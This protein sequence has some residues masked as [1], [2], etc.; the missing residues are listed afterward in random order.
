MPT[1]MQSTK[2]EVLYACSTAHPTEQPSGRGALSA[3][4][5]V[6]D[7]FKLCSTQA[8]AKL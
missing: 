8:C 3:T 4:A 5:G 7:I 2:I 1:P 6:L